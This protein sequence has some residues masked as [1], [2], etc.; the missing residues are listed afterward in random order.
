MQGDPATFRE[1]EEAGLRSFFDV[2][3]GDEKAAEATLFEGNRHIRPWI[4]ADLAID[5]EPRSKK[6]RQLFQAFTQRLE[7]GSHVMVLYT[8]TLTAEAL[9]ERVPPPATP[10]GFL[11]W[12]AGCRWFKDWYIAE[13]FREG[14]QKLQ[15]N[16][17]ASEEARKERE[18][19]ALER[20]QDFLNG[21][22]RFGQCESLAR[23]VVASID[24]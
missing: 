15:G 1:T 11:L 12:K 21:E 18:N 3:L 8:D 16:I 9:N 2:F 19:E 10:I 17:P 13:G 4:E 20:L 24:E 22:T 23:D 5:V 6:H 7:P 14:G